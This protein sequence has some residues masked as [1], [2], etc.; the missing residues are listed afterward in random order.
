MT[1]REHAKL[2][3]IDP[4]GQWCSHQAV[5]D[6]IVRCGGR[7]FLEVGCGAGRLSRW[8]CE[9]GLTGRAVDMSASAIAE[10]RRYLADFVR[11]GRVH[12]DHADVFSEHNG[13]GYDLVVSLMVMEHVQDDQAFARQ[14]AAL[15]NPGGHLIIGVPGRRDRWGIEDETVGHWRRYERGDLTR[16]LES[17]GLR[18]VEVWSVAVPVA[19]LLFHAGNMFLRLGGEDA[20]KDTL[21][22]QAQTEHSGIREIPFKTMFPP[23]FRLVLNRYTMAPLFAL[24]RLFYQ[25]NRGLT[26]IGFGERAA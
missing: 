7:T 14:L 11:D 6:A 17:A 19:N 25:S 5:Y 9:H 4:P 24:Q 1:R 23:V 20:K 10:A 21:S 26:L 8:L 16:V 22:R 15:A 13:D 2:V 3:R 12:V 18:N